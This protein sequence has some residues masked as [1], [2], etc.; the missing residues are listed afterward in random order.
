MFCYNANTDSIELC[1]KP[2]GHFLISADL[3]KKVEQIKNGQYDFGC[4]KCPLSDRNELNEDLADL[5]TDTSFHSGE[6]SA[7][8]LLRKGPGFSVLRNP[9]DMDFS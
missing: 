7:Q 8:N 1:I 5:W 9:D 6:S 2:Y 3:E 4:S